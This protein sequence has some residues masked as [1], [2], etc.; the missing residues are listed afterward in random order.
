M[1]IYCGGQLLTEQNL[2]TQLQTSAQQDIIDLNN[3]SPFHQKMTDDGTALGSDDMT[4][5]GSSGDI[6]F[7]VEANP[8]K[9]RFIVSMT[10]RLGGNGADM[11]E[12]SNIA[13]LTN[14]C[15]V[16]Y[17]TDGSEVILTL[18][19]IKTNF[20]LIVFAQA[21]PTFGNA[22]DVFRVQNAVTNVDFYI[23]DVNFK[24]HWGLDKGMLLKAGSSDKI[25]WR[26]RDDLTTV[27]TFD[28]IAFGFDQVELS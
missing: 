17:E 23:P 3:R 11:Q 4:V 7:W 14:G 10:V 28:S 22:A 21:L 24:R 19:P 2:L 13:A 5:D 9:N 15:Q 20:G 25:I 16:I 6:D 27:D 1:P 26:I 12:F 18:R 8:T